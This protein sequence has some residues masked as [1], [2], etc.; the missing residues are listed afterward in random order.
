MPRVALLDSSQLCKKSGCLYTPYVQNQHYFFSFIVDNLFMRR[1][2][3]DFAG[4]PQTLD[5]I[6]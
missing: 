6:N 5:A 4:Y 1:T 3:Q 2:F